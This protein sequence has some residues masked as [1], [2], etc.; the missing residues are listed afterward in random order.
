MHNNQV[1]LMINNGEL[2]VGQ[3]SPYI[4]LA[5]NIGEAVHTT[6]YRTG[7]RL[8]GDAGRLVTIPT[9]F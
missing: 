5:M 2:K 8:V 4:D 1:M 3:I 6:E 9:R 7:T